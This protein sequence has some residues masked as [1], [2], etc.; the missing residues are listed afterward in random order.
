MMSTSPCPTDRVTDAARLGA[1]HRYEILDT[2]PE[3]TFDRFTRLVGRLFRADA[4]INFVDDRRQWPKSSYGAPSGEVGLETSLCAL[5][6][7]S[8]APLVL[9]DAAA[10]ERFKGAPA[11]VDGLRFYAG[12]PLTTT[13]GFDLG[14][15]CLASR[16]PRGA[17]GAE[18]LA[19]LTDFAHLV[20]GELEARRYAYALAQA[21]DF[22]RIL[23]QNA[24]D[25]ML[26]LSP[27]GL[28]KFVNPAFSRATGYDAAGWLGKSLKPLIHPEDS[29]LAV[30]LFERAA[31]GESGRAE[32]RLFAAEGRVLTLDVIAVPER[33]SGETISVLLFARDISAQKR[34]ERLAA[35]AGSALANKVT[36]LKRMTLRLQQANRE[37]QHSALHDPLTDL[38]NRAGFSG[39]L[40]RAL[41]QPEAPFAVLYLDFDG[42]TLI[43]DS[44]GYAV[45]DEV[46]RLIATRLR[47]EVKATD[48][49]ARFGSDEFLVLL[50]NVTQA[51]ALT[52]ARRLQRHFRHPF[53]VGGHKLRLSVSVGVVASAFF[54]LRA[55]DMLQ[56]AAIAAH[57]AK[58]AGGARVELFNARLR[59][60]RVRRLSVEDELRGA[61]RQGQLE[62]FYQPVFYRPDRMVQ[63]IAGLEA[64]VRWRKPDGSVLLPGAFISVA[65]ESG[66]IT[67]LD[68]WVLAE[69]C[70][71]VAAWQR[72]FAWPELALGVNLSAHRLHKGA[73]DLVK[74]VRTLVARS[75]LAP[76]RLLLEVTESTLLHASKGLEEALGQLKSLGV[77][78]SLDDFGTGYSSLSQLHRFPFD[79]LKIDRSFVHPMTRGA[80]SAELVRTMILMAQNLGLGVVAE[81]VETE[82]Q[83][84]HL[85]ELGCPYLQGYLFAKPLSA[86]ETE[87]L[88]ARAAA[89][90][91]GAPPVGR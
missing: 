76:D 41:A 49:V 64:L 69:A 21:E 91:S 63:R 67:D 45:G 61:L 66:L 70:R 90:R 48:T 30:A 19:T 80:K 57:H 52:A 54:Y 37:L 72:A 74:E 68:R 38:P 32:L 2:A 75:G 5:V 83:A 26:R 14:T 36:R 77:R 23:V 56:D 58:R 31:R 59:E 40:R 9:L 81:G 12:V 34:T 60:A 44:L 53:L 87:K 88:L 11:V 35:H 1:L 47:N 79:L 50:G 51:E 8:G 17:F 62:V 10:D 28:C 29:T 39:Q 43:N 86:P 4:Y 27:E 15:L 13:D 22:G 78:L 25:G 16:E 84:A 71:Q 18:D 55:D 82:E 85:I 24:H 3:E 7:S 65:E 20:V 89:E 46:L 6:V 42:F 33:R 73:P